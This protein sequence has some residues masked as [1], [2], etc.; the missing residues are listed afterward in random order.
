MAIEEWKSMGGEECD[1]C[2]SCA[3]SEFDLTKKLGQSRAN[4]VF[5]RHWQSWFNQ[6]DV[7]TLVDLKIK[8]V[9]LRR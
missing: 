7:D 2:S 6:T 3:S 5:K 1:D 4:Q 9:R 8:C